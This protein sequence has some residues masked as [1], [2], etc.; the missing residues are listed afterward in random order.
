MSLIITNLINTIIMNTTVILIVNK[1]NKNK[2]N[3][4][5]RKNILWLLFSTLPVF[6][7]TTH[8]YNL[9]STCILP[10]FLSLSLSKIFNF[11]IITSVIIELYILLVSVIPDLFGSLFL[12]NFVTLNQI[13]ETPYFMIFTNTFVA[14][15]VYLLF[16]IQFIKKV[17][18]KGIEQIQQKKLRKI[19]LFLLFSFIAICI[20][21]FTATKIF[22]PTKDYFTSNI[23]IIIFL[24]LAFIYVL[25]IIKYNNLQLQNNTLYECMQNVENYQEQQ[26][27]RMHE[28]K[29]QLSK[30]IDATTDDNVI[31]IVKSIL[32]VD[33]SNENYILG[34]IK[35]LPKGEIKSL[36][37]YKL[38]VSN[39][40]NLNTSIDISPKLKEE[41]FKL[42]PNVNNELSQLIGIY[43][44]NAIEAASNSPK[45]QIALEVYKIRNSL[46]FV[47][48]NSYK[49]SIKLN[50]IIKKG[51]STK[52]S[53]R[54][55]G[56]YFAN[57]I[58]NNSNFFNS[59]TKIIDDYFIQ[60]LEV[61][62]KKDI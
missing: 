5:T 30:V 9:V 42:P 53:S 3:I 38:L 34:K 12:I 25:E 46:F 19:M 43:F 20:T 23:V 52:G 1:I 49:G 11:D 32:K 7:Y 17:L 47:I 51:F 56:L 50:N 13:R 27:L 44:D 54:G 35:Y 55:K 60:R 28:Y 48:T 6:L 39:K 2:F 61:K 59:E 24:F 29:N 22:S 45:K 14:I 4:F 8:D 58:I 15:S 10:L 36:I 62:I 16:Y 40:Q 31:S 41:D 37:Y 26:D 33:S 21:Y 18:L 57:K